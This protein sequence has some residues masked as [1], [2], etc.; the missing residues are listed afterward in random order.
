MKLLLVFKIIVEILFELYF[1]SAT[2]YDEY[3][4]LHLEQNSSLVM[5][6]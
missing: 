5:L 4:Q 6:V 3:S 1:F 2:E